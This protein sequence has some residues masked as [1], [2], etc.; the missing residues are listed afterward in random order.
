MENSVDRVVQIGRARLDR[1]RGIIVLD[2]PGGDYEIDLSECRTPAE[3][4]DWIRHLSE[5]VWWPEVHDDFTAILEALADEGK[6]GE[7]NGHTKHRTA[8]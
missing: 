4:A 7:G 5:K 8:G 2:T 3:V 6:G 1:E